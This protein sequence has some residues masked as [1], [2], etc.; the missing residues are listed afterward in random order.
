MNNKKIARVSLTL[1]ITYDIK[2]FNLP[3]DATDMDIYKKVDEA[4]TDLI[5]KIY[6]ATGWL[7]N[8]IEMD[9]A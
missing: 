9:L 6:D 3:E 5:E 8:D 2:D 1:L 4:N 7:V